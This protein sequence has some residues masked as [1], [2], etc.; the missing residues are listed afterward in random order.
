MKASRYLIVLIGFFVFSLV[1]MGSLFR[2]YVLIFFHQSIYYCQ[3]V[4]DGLPVRLPN[5]LG[6]ACLMVFL[7]TLSYITIKLVVT[8]IKTLKIGRNLSLSTVRSTVVKKTAKK[9]GLQDKLFVYQSDHHSAFCFGFFNTKIYVST[10]L[11]NILSEIELEAVIR[12]ERYHLENKDALT[13]LFAL[14]VQTMFPFFPV[15]SDISK[16]YR[17]L[18]EVGADEAAI[19]E[20]KNSKSLISVLKKLLSYGHKNT[21]NFGPSL[22]EWDTLEYRVKKLVNQKIER[23]RFPITNII[24][25]FASLV[26]LVGLS[27][28]RINAVEYHDR[29]GDAVLLCSKDKNCTNICE[30][31]M[32]VVSFSHN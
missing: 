23:R 5:N 6:E 2:K 22:G 25:S 32:E 18:N 8:M 24:V 28:S 17:I 12:H 21:F 7:I 15:I 19:K 1:M 27:L 31:Q 30:S 29:G 11:V 4:V 3:Q 26:I 9:L 10:G 20:M 16:R 14:V 13:F